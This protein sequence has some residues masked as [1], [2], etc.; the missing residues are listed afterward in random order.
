MCTTTAT[1]VVVGAV[2]HWPSPSWP[3]AVP[4]IRVPGEFRCESTLDYDEEV[5][6]QVFMAPVFRGD[7]DEF[8]RQNW[9]IT[10]WIDAFRNV[11][12]KSR[13]VLVADAPEVVE[14][15]RSRDLPYVCVTRTPFGPPR[16]DEI[17]KTMHRSLK[18]GVVAYVNADICVPRE[19]QHRSGRSSIEKILELQIPEDQQAPVQTEWGR[20][21]KVPGGGKNA[22]WLA[23]GRRVDLS[24]STA[25]VHKGGGYD[26]WAWNVHP[27][28]R[29]LLP[30]RIPPFR[31]ARP[32][33][34]NWFLS[35]SIS[36]GFRHVIDA[37]T[38]FVTLHR[39]HERYFS[40]D[41]K[42]GKSSGGMKN[43]Y[44]SGNVDAYINLH[45]AFR[46]YTDV[47]TGR[48]YTYGWTHGTTCEAPFYLGASWTV[49]RRAIRSNFNCTPCYLPPSLECPTDGV[50]EYL[51]EDWG[52]A[53]VDLWTAKTRESAY[54]GLLIP[55]KRSNDINVVPAKLRAFY[56]AATEHWPYT[57]EAILE[58]RATNPGK[59]VVLISANVAA[60][61]FASN[62]HCNMQRIGVDHH[63]LA[64]MDDD[65]YHWAVLNAIPVF[66]AGSIVPEIETNATVF[67]ARDFEHSTKDV[68]YRIITKVKSL[69]VLEVLK[70]GYHVL[71]SDIDVIWIRNPLSFFA[72]ALLVV[73]RPAMYVQANAPMILPPSLDTTIVFNFSDTVSRLKH[74]EDC[75]KR[76]RLN[77]GLYFVP[78]TDA[79]IS[80]FRHITIDAQN[81]PDKSEQPSFQRALCLTHGRKIADDACLYQKGT[82][83]E[84]YV[85]ALPRLQFA[86]GAVFTSPRDRLIF[87]ANAHTA[88]DISPPIYALHYNYI[89]GGPQK[90]AAITNQQFWFLDS[91]GY[92]R[93]PKHPNKN[94]RKEA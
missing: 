66:H 53:I 3:E 9:S 21:E 27:G 84:L 78:A 26:F 83:A 55:G 35:V 30:F 90:K 93:F 69:V 25:T 20:F 31:V 73:D 88:L 65:I 6:F 48:N 72:R 7:A 52:R 8:R 60:R 23:V 32:N 87:Q 81:H 86:T 46:H 47:R 5:E 79:G 14:Y 67:D 15:S 38:A 51:G 92:C 37:T 1:V 85:Y 54:R 50:G 13:L 45:M 44:A 36:V 76:N 58:K 89:E 28:C 16:F 12:A 34:D 29:P 71:F 64:A 18:R 82:S 42:K 56:E 74:E 2:P 91:E 40:D 17:L 62:F 63:V 41:R 19:G 4:E 10:S 57:M 49:E 22:D 70:A 59:I 11:R 24:G 68:N 80:A 61:D 43:Y 39:E 77:S 94:F 33:F 75:T